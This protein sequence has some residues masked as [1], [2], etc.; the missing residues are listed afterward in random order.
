ME[1]LFKLMPLE[2]ILNIPDPWG[3]KLIFKVSVARLYDNPIYGTQPS[4]DLRIRGEMMQLLP[5]SLH[6]RGP[7]PRNDAGHTPPLLMRGQTKSLATNSLL[8]PGC[9]NSSMP[10]AQPEE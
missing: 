7:Q 1:N 9:P 2:I 10:G 6:Q 8:L 3:H 4:W 5:V